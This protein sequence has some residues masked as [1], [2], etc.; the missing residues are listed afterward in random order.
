MEQIGKP[1]LRVVSQAFDLMTSR[2]EKSRE[3][4]KA[5]KEFMNNKSS[6]NLDSWVL[7]AAK[8]ERAVINFGKLK[9]RQ[10]DQMAGEA[11]EKTTI[12]K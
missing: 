2:D 4:K 7:A 1:A 8:D 11:V 5:F 3:A 6:A 10:R 12:R 9:R